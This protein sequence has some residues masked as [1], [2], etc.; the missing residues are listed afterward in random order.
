[1][2]TIA[3]GMAACLAAV[4]LIG[5]LAEGAGAQSVRPNCDR[6]AR[7]YANGQ[8]TGNT[9]GGALGGALLGAGIGALVGGGHAIGTGA[10]IGAGA[11][12]VGGVATGSA[13]WRQNYNDRFYSCMRGN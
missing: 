9:V 7:E 8:A 5:C 10:A 1:M 4:V 3:R 2:K 11:G 13:A 6:I 12:A